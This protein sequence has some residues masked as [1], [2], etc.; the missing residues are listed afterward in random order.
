MLV[1]TTNLDGRLMEMVE[2]MRDAAGRLR[3]AGER[4]LAVQVIGSRV[5]LVIPGKQMC[6]STV[7]YWRVMSA[8]R[9]V[10]SRLR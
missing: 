5:G 1:Q 10:V 6:V 2:L 7:D 8:H 4:V 3:L 9:L